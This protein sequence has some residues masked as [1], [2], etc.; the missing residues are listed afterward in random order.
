M[1]VNV[2]DKSNLA[3][4]LRLN[5]R[6]FGETLPMATPSQAVKTEGVETR[7]DSSRTEEGIVQTTNRNGS[8]NYSSK[9]IL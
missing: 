8:E 1:R 3:G 9:K 7:H 5:S 4:M 6:K 2:V